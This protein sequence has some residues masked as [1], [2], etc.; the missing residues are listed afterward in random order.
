MPL[1]FFMPSERKTPPDTGT[2]PVLVAELGRLVACGQLGN[3]HSRQ[4]PDFGLRKRNT[5]PLGPKKEA[6]CI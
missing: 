5:G 6:R 3:Y 4:L 1:V 2:V